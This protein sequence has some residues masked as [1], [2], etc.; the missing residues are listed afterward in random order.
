MNER[1]IY[2][3]THTAAGGIEVSPE[4]GEPESQCHGLVMI[5]I[6]LIKFTAI[7]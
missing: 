7:Y 2:E 1:I 5:L 3:Q 6:K 4:L